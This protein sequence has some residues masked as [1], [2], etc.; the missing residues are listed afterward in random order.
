MHW[1]RY[2]NFNGHFWFNPFI[3]LCS[4]DDFLVSSCIALFFHVGFCCIS[5]CECQRI[6]EPFVLA[7]AARIGQGKNAEICSLFC[8]ILQGGAEAGTVLYAAKSR[9]ASWIGLLCDTRPELQAGSNYK[10][11]LLLCLQNWAK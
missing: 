9:S 8:R 6:F 4:R 2:F 7:W 5:K 10:A 3:V 1:L 11:Q